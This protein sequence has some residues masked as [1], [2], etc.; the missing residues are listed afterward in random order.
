[1]TTAALEAEKNRKLGVYEKESD[2]LEVF[3]DKQKQE[4]IA[5]KQDYDKDIERRKRLVV[6]ERDEEDAVREGERKESVH[7]H[8]DVTK[9]FPPFGSLL[10]SFETLVE[11]IAMLK[12]DIYTLERKF[13]DKL[14][15][16]AEETSNQYHQIRYQVSCCCCCL[17]LC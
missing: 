1:M 6:D 16:R 10:H 15:K 3:L 8:H 17:I 12:K 5:R 14:D 4:A 13:E 7:R 2:K 11:D 9:E